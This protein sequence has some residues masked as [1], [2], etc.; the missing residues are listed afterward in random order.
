ML[1]EGVAQGIYLERSSRS[2][3]GLIPTDPFSIN[4]LAYPATTSYNP[5][6]CRLRLQ[7]PLL[8]SM[9]CAFPSTS[10]TTIGAKAYKG[11]TYETTRE[12]QAHQTTSTRL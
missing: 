10:T 6:I 3:L 11:Q 4:H 12:S 1:L 5:N 8:H 7:P 9:P 2:Q